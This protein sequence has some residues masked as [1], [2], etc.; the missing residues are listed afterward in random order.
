MRCCRQLRNPF[1][2]IEKR[3]SPLGGSKLADGTSVPSEYKLWISQ[4]VY[5]EFT[6]LISTHHEDDVVDFSEYRRL[7]PGDNK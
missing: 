5:M 7:Y 3:T 1:L 6:K 4:H 2:G